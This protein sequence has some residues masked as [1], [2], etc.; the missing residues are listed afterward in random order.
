MMAVNQGTPGASAGRVVLRMSPAIRIHAANGQPLNEQPLSL[1]PRIMFGSALF[2]VCVML[3]IVMGA[4]SNWPSRSELEGEDGSPPA[5][6]DSRAAVATEGPIQGA[7]VTA[8]SL[9]GEAKRRRT[10]SNRTKPFI[11]ANCDRFSFTYCAGGGAQRHYYDWTVGSCVSTPHAGPLLCNRGRNRFASLE[12]CRRSCMTRKPPSRQCSMP[13]SFTV[14]SRR[15]MK[16]DLWFWDGNSCSKTACLETCKE[17]SANGTQEA[18]APTACRAAR[19]APC[20]PAKMRFPFFA[21][22]ER[23]G[24][25]G[26]ECV[27]ASA[28]RLQR[29]L[30]LAP[31]NM[32]ASIEACDETCKRGGSEKN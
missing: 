20:S 16:H 23:G 2:C 5:V 32:F 30:C 18:A 4:I 15:D 17:P 10:K 26:F 28:E 19:S 3:V 1:L 13:A 27:E 7:K 9:E 29:R 25:G 12:H 8:S 6:Q 24:G 14:C 22:R 11:K 21:A 31:G